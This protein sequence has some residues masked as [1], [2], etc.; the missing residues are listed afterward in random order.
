MAPA[1]S[2]AGQCTQGH[3][4]TAGGECEA[5]A[6]AA[7]PA[8]G[9][10]PLPLPLAEVS[11]AVLADEIIIFGDGTLGT[12]DNRYTLTYNLTAQAFNDVTSAAPRP[13]WGDHSAVEVFNGELFAF[14]GLCCQHFCDGCKAKSR[15]QIFNPATNVWRE[16]QPVPWDLDGAAATALIGNSIHICG[17]LSNN[18]VTTK[19]GIYSPGTD[20]WSS[21][22]RMPKAAHHTA[23]GTD[24]A[25]FYIFGGRQRGNTLSQPIPEVQIY[26][27]ES[28]TWVSSHFPGSGIPPMPTPRTG[29]GKAAFLRGEFYIL[30]GEWYPEDHPD[31][32]DAGTFDLVEIYNPETRTWRMGPRMPVG[33]HGLHPV[34]WQDQILV[35]GGNPFIDRGASTTF[36]VYAPASS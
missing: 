8:N 18:F 6:W 13:Y 14:A 1:V 23:A 3:V 7:A 36:Q 34:V 35:L 11:A 22:P 19:C 21:M 16:G 31:V 27:P 20:T 10:S 4:P 17:G 12:Q 26:D 5:Y 24:G 2:P 30:G 15:V 9:L 32:L 25:K 29:M 28:S 33:L